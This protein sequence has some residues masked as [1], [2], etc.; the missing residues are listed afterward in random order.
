MITIG[1]CRCVLNTDYSILSYHMRHS[2]TTRFSHFEN[3]AT[4]FT[5][6]R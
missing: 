1:R 4:V 2:T 6:L 5:I 3:V